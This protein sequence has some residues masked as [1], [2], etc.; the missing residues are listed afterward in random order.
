[1]LSLSGRSGGANGGTLKYQSRC[2]FLPDAGSRE[3]SRSR[4]LVPHILPHLAVIGKI[5][6]GP[7]S[8]ICLSLAWYGKD[9]AFQGYCLVEIC[10]G[11]CRGLPH[12]EERPTGRVSKDGPRAS[13]FETAHV[14][15]L[16][17]RGGISQLTPR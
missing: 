1:M 7:D 14:R 13:W 12:P 5:G 8:R 2:A 15:L 10:L 17:V 9:T 4:K 11:R 6:N 16:T 3:L